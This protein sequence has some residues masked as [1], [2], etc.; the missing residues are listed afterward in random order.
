MEFI[1]ENGRPV[2]RIGQ[3]TWYLGENAATAVR[4]RKALQAGV[5]AGMNLIDT[6]EMYGEGAAEHLIGS[7]IRGMDRASLYLVSKVYPF[8]ADR[9]SIFLSCENSLR[10]LGTDYLDLYLLHWRGSVPLAETVECMEQLKAKGRI[11][12]WGVSNFDALD[13]DELMDVDGGNQCASNQVLYHLGSE[14]AVIGAG[15]SAMDVARTA[16]R[17]G[18]KHVT[19][20]CR[21]DKPA[22]SVREV[23][24][25]LADGVEFLYGIH[26]ER[27]TDRGVEYRQAAFDEEGQVTG[28]G[29][30]ALFLADSVIIAVSQGPK[31]KIVNTTHGLNTTDH[32]LLATDET[33]HT[34]RPGIFASGDVVLGAR[35]VVEAVKYSKTVAAAMDEYLQSLG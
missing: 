4:E 9:R 35:T 30:P 24:Y 31:D 17:K 25:A 23:D 21:S 34:S 28:M 27:I 26:S 8:N 12:A 16:L 13:M 33:G 22:A 3:G 29:E 14:V 1:T 15:N 18:A 11:R 10:R 6:A 5:E 19:I 20:L 32:G 7:A 2:S